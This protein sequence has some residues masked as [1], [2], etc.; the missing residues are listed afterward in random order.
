MMDPVLH[1]FDGFYPA[2]GGVEAYIRDLAQVTEDPGLVITDAIR[3]LPEEE[4]L[5]PGFSVRRVGPENPSLDAHPRLANHRAFFPARLLAD[6]LRVRRKLKVV[7]RIPCRILQV[8]GL[9]VPGTVFR[10]RLERAPRFLLR[11]LADFG[12]VKA[13]KIAT[14]HGLLSRTS[15][16]RFASLERQFYR[17]FDHLACVDRSLIRFIRERWGPAS[18]EMC[19]HW[20]PN[21]VDTDFFEYAEP[22]EDRAV[23]IGFVGRL[24]SSRGLEALAV[25][26]RSL[27]QG[28]SLRIAGA[29]SFR[30][31]ERFSELMPPERMDIRFNASRADVRSMLR[32]VD[33]LF[34]PV[35]VDGISRASL[36]ALATGR[37]VAMFAGEDRHPV[38]PGETG[39]LLERT[40]EAVARWAATLPARKEELVRMG[41]RGR[42]LVTREYSLGHF[43]R[44]IEELYR[45]AEEGTP[46]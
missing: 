46:A 19:L 1:Y 21:G 34:N 44:R 27:P 29:G 35:L 2:S 43:G 15:G 36:E 31:L 38:V 24:E 16:G 32:S 25:L 8:H 41:R 45:H 20:C 37:P 18:E 22:P 6:T 10:L 4:A 12:P 5:R 42:E 9:N 7:R 33:V 11:W 28:A 23:H 17:S 39:F 14:V 13:P 40:D 30:D 3:G 26:A